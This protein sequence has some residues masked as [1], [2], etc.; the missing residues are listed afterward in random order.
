MPREPLRVLRIITR[1]NIGGPAREIAALCRRAEDHGFRTVLAAGCPAESEGDLF[2]SLEVGGSTKV[3]VRSLR[4]GVDPV[5]DARAF[6]ALRSLVRRFDPHIVHTHTSK[7]GLLGRMVVRR[8]S[9]PGV[10]HTFHGD[11]FQGHFGPLASR[12]ILATERWLGRRTD[13]LVVLGPRSKERL[14]QH[15]IGRRVEVIPPGFDH[16]RLEALARTDRRA[17][18][19]RFRVPDERPVLLVLGRL[20]RVKGVDVLLRALARCE[21]KGARC[22]LLIAG[23]GPERAALETQARGLGLEGVARFLGWQV[24]VAP[25]I[26]AAD[27]LVLPSRSEGYPHALVEARAAGLGVVASAVGEVPGLVTEG[28]SG[29]LVPP[30][31][32]DALAACLEPLLLEPQRLAAARSRPVPTAPDVLSEAD[33]A[34]RTCAL[35]RELLSAAG[36]HGR[37]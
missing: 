32:V 35:Y 11:V 4:R 19:R 33:M 20:A 25:V 9:V 26:G 14:E 5:R 3:R 21:R 1:L 23:D 30:D 6:A 12:A 10:C 34:A 15:G 28:P 37:G 27:L 2:D 36:P 13:A 16:R 17:C 29:R 7:A 31:R 24:D 22:V 8:R 18:R